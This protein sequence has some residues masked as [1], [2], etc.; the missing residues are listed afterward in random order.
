ML[1]ALT[2]DRAAL[3]RLISSTKALGGTTLYDAVHSTL[4]RL[5]RYEGRKAIIV[6]SDGEDTES[7][8][9]YKRLLEEAKSKD[10]T[11]YTIALGSGFAEPGSRDKLKGL[12]EQTGGRFFSANKASQL[13]GIYTAI[14]DTL[15]NQ[16]SLTYASDNE[17]FDGRW[18]EIRIEGKQKGLDVRA[19][20]GYFALNPKG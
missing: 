4:G 2:N 18:I 8:L 14:A 9:D 3:K 20:K 17:R 15:R 6:L 10:A 19:R 5:G 16:Y 11:I 7:K 12:A 1:S 13:E